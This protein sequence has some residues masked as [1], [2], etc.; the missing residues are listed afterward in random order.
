VG[1]GRSAAAGAWAGF[2]VGAELVA[3]AAAAA[4]AV[5]GVGCSLQARTRP[6]IDRGLLLLKCLLVGFYFKNKVIKNGI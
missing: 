4:V 3:G 1:A 5:A 2:E 6:R